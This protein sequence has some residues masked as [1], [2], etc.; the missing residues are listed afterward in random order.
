MT[1]L[2]RRR[3]HDNAASRLVPGVPRNKGTAA[4]MP[5]LPLTSGSLGAKKSLCLPW[6]SGRRDASDSVLV[7]VF[8]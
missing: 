8:G 2:G 1:I 7:S 3:V 4:H 6:R 5:T